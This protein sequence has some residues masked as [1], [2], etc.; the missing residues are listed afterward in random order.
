[1]TVCVG[2]ASLYMGVGNLPFSTL[3]NKDVF[4][5]ESLF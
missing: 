3:K 5:V 1:M 4:S 2:L